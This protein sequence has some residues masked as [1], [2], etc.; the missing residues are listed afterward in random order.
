MVLESVFMVFG[1]NI[2]VFEDDTKVFGGDGMVFRGYANVFESDIKFLEV[3]P[4]HL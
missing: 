1:G 2:K 3:I 4:R